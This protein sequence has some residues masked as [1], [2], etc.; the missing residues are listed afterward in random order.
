MLKHS[1]DF[2][3][4][5]VAELQDDKSQFAVDLSPSH[6]IGGGALPRLVLSSLLDLLTLHLNSRDGTE[7]RCT[8][9][10]GGGGPVYRIAGIG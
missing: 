1:M 4:C 9:S 5:K 6:A 3:S 7:K 10:Q 2:A 8:R